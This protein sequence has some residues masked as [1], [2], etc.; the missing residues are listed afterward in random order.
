MIDHTPATTRPSV[1]DTIA[2]RMHTRDTGEDRPVVIP[3][4]YAA[5]VLTPE[6]EKEAL[7]LLAA[8]NRAFADKVS[9]WR[10][11]HRND[12]PLPGGRAAELARDELIALREY[13]RV[14]ELDLSQLQASFDALAGVNSGLRVK[15][16]ALTI[17]VDGWRARVAELG[18]AY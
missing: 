10:S 7:A 18:G 4:E 11:P 8:E 3:T 1:Y 5:L 9:G 2:D 6:Q 17:E 16:A 12:A 14:A 13:K 15:V